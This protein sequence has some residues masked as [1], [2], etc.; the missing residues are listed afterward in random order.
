MASQPIAA[1]RAI[2]MPSGRP[3]LEIALKVSDLV[4]S[5]GAVYSD[6]LHREILQTKPSGID[7]ADYQRY[8]KILDDEEANAVLRVVWRESQHVTPEALQNVKLYRHFEDGSLTAWG[9]A[10]RMAGTPAELAA[11][12]SRIRNIVIAS[13]A[14]GLVE[15]GQIS[16][17]N[18]PIV[19]TE[20]LHHFIVKLTENEFR[21]LAD[22]GPLLSLLNPS[23]GSPT[24]D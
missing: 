12:S 3:V 21:L 15:R 17:T 13:Q 22:L 19:G 23:L 7:R 9:M 11:T 24:S 6:L 20:L 14:F 1:T 2:L 10:T 5:L 4:I 8:C 18:K 16:S